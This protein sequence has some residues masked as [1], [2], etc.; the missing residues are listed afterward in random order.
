MKYNI[1]LV[2]KKGESVYAWTMISLI[3]LICKYPRG[4][5]PRMMMFSLFWHSF[6]LCRSFFYYYF[7]LCHS[8]NNIY[9]NTL[10]FYYFSIIIII[11]W[12]FI[13]YSIYFLFF[14]NKFVVQFT[15]Y[16]TFFYYK[17]FSKISTY[18]CIYIQSKS[19]NIKKLSKCINK[20]NN[21]FVYA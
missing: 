8:C 13:L 16:I 10:Y 2:L 4:K 18:I 6:L 19:M 21:K 12:S 15:L 5:P 7:L 17:M 20:Y 11:L 3:L 1:H 9:N 14:I